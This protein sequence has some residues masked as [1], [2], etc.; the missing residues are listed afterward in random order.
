ML[1]RSEENLDSFNEIV[2]NLQNDSEWKAIKTQNQQNLLDS[3]T[4]SK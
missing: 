3:G 2:N 4:K 1:S